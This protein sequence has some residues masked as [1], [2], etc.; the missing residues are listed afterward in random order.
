[1]KN[2]K[3]SGFIFSSNNHLFFPYIVFKHEELFDFLEK[4][5]KE[6][7]CVISVY[8]NT[9]NYIVEPVP[10]YAKEILKKR[11]LKKG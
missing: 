7:D 8:Q 10:D 6:T 11:S 9:G 3:Y 2:H 1:M 4:V 5:E